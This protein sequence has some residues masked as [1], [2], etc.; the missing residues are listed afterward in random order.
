MGLTN[1]LLENILFGDNG[2]KIV[3]SLTDGEM[4]RFNESTGKIEGS[5]DINGADSVDFGAK[6]LV[7][8]T[9]VTESQSVDIGA[10]NTLSDIGGYLKVTSNM[11]GNSFLPID[12]KLTP[13][14][15]ERPTWDKRI[16]L[17][18]KDVIQGDDSQQMLNVSSYSINP[19]K[20]QD[21][22]KVYLKLVNPVTNFRAV[23]RSS[24]T[25]EITKHIPD[26]ASYDKDIGLSLGSGEQF[27]DI[28]SAIGE[29]Q[30]TIV[31]IEMLA[32]Q[33]IDLL[34]NGTDPWRAIDYQ[35]IPSKIGVVVETDI[36]N[37]NDMASNSEEKIPT[38]RSVKTYVDNSIKS[39]QR[40][41]AT[42]TTDLTIGAQTIVPFEQAVKSVGITLDPSGSIVVSEDGFYHGNF[43][44]YLQESG[45]P[46]VMIWMECKPLATGVW[47]LCSGAMIKLKFKDSGGNSVS[48]NGGLDLLAGDE[49]RIM[50]KAISGGGTLK[51]QTE[52][53][54][55]GVITQPAASLSIF[56]VN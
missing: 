18:I 22:Y 2:Y 11:S 15:S 23:I 19:P 17:V 9:V 24:A 52:T 44:L 26:R 35:D 46:L 47:H 7:C 1:I 50:V 39:V 43:K 31:T 49:F 54:D 36:I 42:R 51:T 20:D 53:T 21:V 48:L 45:D 38:Q 25:G 14:G 29:I 28:P 55:L 37:E 10:G 4:L 40:I 12:S 33:S 8:K 3:G 16:A 30:G 32:D 6:N 56:R 27:F 41:V 5:G 34:G 13:N